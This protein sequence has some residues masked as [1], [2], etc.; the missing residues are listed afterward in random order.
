VR[1]SSW[2]SRVLAPALALA[3]ACSP[4]RPIARREP[5]VVRV[6]DAEAS[7]SIHV[8][9]EVMADDVAGSPADHAAGRAETDRRRVRESVRDLARIVGDVSG[10]R[11]TIETSAP[12][13]VSNEPVYRILVGEYGAKESGPVGVTAPYGQGFRAVVSERAAALY[14]ETNLATSYAIYELLDRIGCRWFFPGPLGEVLPVRGR[15]ALG[16]ADDRLAPST[17]YRGVWYADEAWKRRN[18]QG[19]LKIEAGHALE[20]DYVSKEDRA[21]HPEWVATI[22]GR[23]HPS[24]LRWSSPTLARHVADKILERRR[25]PTGTPS[26]G[27]PSYSI[28]PDDGMDFDESSEDRALDANDVDASTGTKSLT[29]RFL[30]LANGIASHVS[31]RDPEVLLG[32]LAYV[33]YTRP[34][35]RERVHPSLVPE[36]APITYSRAHP[37]ND[38]RVPGNQDLRRGIEGW[39]KLAK[40]GTSI[41]FYGWF[42]AEPVAPNPMLTKW[43]HDVPYVL[44]HNAKYWQPETFPNFESSMHALYMGMRVAFDARRRP[45]DVYADIDARLYGAAGKTMHAYWQEVDHTWVD[46]AEYSGGV[47]GHTRRF[48][49]KRLA[50]MRELLDAGKTAAQTETERRRVELADDSLT[51]FEEL[52]RL[53]RD[54]VDGR[55]EGLAASGE[56]YKKHAS[57]LGEKW[58]EASA[59]SQAVYAPET[60]YSKYYDALQKPSYV[61]ASRIAQTYAIQSVQRTFRYRA[62]EKERAD[63]FAPS[64][65]A[66]SFDDRQW[67][68]TDVAVDSWSALGLHDWFGAMWYR[69]RIK[70]RRPANGKRTFV[71]L[72]SVD[73]AT[74]VFVNGREAHYAPDTGDPAAPLAGGGPL[75]FDVTDLVIDGENAV[76]IHTMRKDLTELGLSGLMGPVVVCSER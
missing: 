65:G 4:A 34:P 60:I 12:S 28:A 20:L 2:L 66:P 69:A 18:R 33:Q 64:L 24:R 5:V 17:A 13:P 56:A 68:S 39:G 3:A 38:D 47:F 26:R 73:G 22:G 1:S 14:G 9:A 52:M 76:A 7:V 37:M 42:L 41:Y 63:T 67:R 61:A 46:A 70:A 53:R 31:E 44:A 55:F 75:R 8:P 15:I 27:A 11:V 19:G 72:T 23:P 71:W 10:A 36:I 74:R 54:F 57:A 59:F 51:L 29:D 62:A 43:G 16:R 45:E 30:H 32:F 25:G 6:L 21:T 49:P 50:R 58:K 48:S 40:S 35:V